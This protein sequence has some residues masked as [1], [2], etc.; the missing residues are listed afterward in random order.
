MYEVGVDASSSLLE[1]AARLMTGRRRV[2]AAS[3]KAKVQ[4][5]KTAKFAKSIVK[6]VVRVREKEK[7]EKKRAA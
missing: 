6:R 2:G 1:L 5:K 7:E 3:T 4:V